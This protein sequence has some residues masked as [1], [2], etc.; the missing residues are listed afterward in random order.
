[1]DAITIAKIVQG[2]DII[3]IAVLITIGA[4]PLVKGLFALVTRKHQRRKEFLDVWKTDALRNDD[5]W[6]EEVI[7]HRYG[8][9]IPAQLI[10]H[11]ARLKCPSRK[12]RKVAMT[13]DF[14]D[15]DD[16]Q[17]KMAWA[18]SWRGRDH[19]IELEMISCLISYIVLATSGSGLILIG[20]RQD[21]SEGFIFVIGGVVFCAAA[22]KTFWHF[23]SLLEA[24]STLALVNGVCRLGFW[25]TLKRKA[26][27]WSSTPLRRKQ[28]PE[29][30]LGTD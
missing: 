12:L 30:V 28:G 23:I 26:A 4:V 6:L 10:R 1:M 20:T 24:R 5:L 2:G 25:H 14:F 15:F 19:R 22:F 16:T 11:I 29:Q 18:V 7:Q 8:A 17:E 27:A 3:P 13:P 9:T 21:L